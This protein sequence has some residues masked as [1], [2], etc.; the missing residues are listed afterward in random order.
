M[1]EIHRFLEANYIRPC[2]YAEWFSNIVL[3]E[4]KDSGKLRVC[5][6]F[7]NLNRATPKDEYPMP[8]ADMLI[9]NASE[10]RVIS[11]LDGNAGYNQIFMAEED[12][13]K[14]AFICP[15]SLGCSS[16]LLWHLV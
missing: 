7:R 5:I 10:N 3:V 4:K 15:A 1:D 11:F 13:S 14:M 16:G 8:I 12:A 2:R 9:N 6:N